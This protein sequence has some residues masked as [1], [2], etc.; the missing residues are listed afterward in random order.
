MLQA[1]FYRLVVFWWLEPEV[2][3]TLSGPPSN[4]PLPAIPW[5]FRDSP[6]RNVIRPYP[7]TMFIMDVVVDCLGAPIVEEAVKLMVLHRAKVLPSASGGNPKYASVHT[8]LGYMLCSAMGLKMADNLRRVSLYTRPTHTQRTFFAFARG[9]FPVHELCAALTAMQ[10]AKKE[11]LG[12]DWSTARILTPA[13]L[14][15]LMGN[16][17]GKK[18]LFKW[19]SV[20]PWAEMQLQAWSTSDDAPPTKVIM[21]G[22]MGL[23][24]LSL[25]VRV[26][27]HLCRRYYGIN[28]E[29]PPRAFHPKV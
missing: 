24:W 2:L 19:G 15:H 8:Y 10:L 28:K 12:R 3:T 27:I 22:C 18:P 14:L 1:T 29:S 26:L 7:A 16:F 5:L 25:L 21:N 13:I 6:H 20:T 23:F 4:L 11:I 17:R 9:I